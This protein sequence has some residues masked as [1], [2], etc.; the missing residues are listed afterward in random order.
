MKRSLLGVCVCLFCFVCERVCVEGAWGSWVGGVMP[1]W[2]MW[3]LVVMRCASMHVNVVFWWGDVQLEMEST[4]FF[5]LHIHI[6]S[7]P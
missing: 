2:G 5:L 1:L 6:T 4:I 7:S 3:G